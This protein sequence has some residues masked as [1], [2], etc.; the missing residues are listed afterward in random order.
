[1]LGKFWLSEYKTLEK[2]KVSLYLCLQLSWQFHCAMIQNNGKMEIVRVWGWV[3]WDP[4]RVR[5]SWKILWIF[6]GQD[7]TQIQSLFTSYNKR[8]TSKYGICL[9]STTKP[10][11]I[12]IKI[13]QH[14][15]YN[16]SYII[17]HAIENNVYCHQPLLWLPLSC[18][19][20][21]WQWDEEYD[22]RSDQI[23]KFHK[24]MGK[25]GNK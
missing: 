20:F 23:R 10:K 13:W 11:S 16:K 2:Y 8:A 6:R 7:K 9:F 4:A 1:M 3:F 14:I 5:M 24:R 15:L 21:L 18:F 25:H 22:I 12:Y 17:I 19:L